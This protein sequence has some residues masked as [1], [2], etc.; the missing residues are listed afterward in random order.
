M[1]ILIYVRKKLRHDAATCKTGSAGR[2]AK[3]R[4]RIAKEGGEAMSSIAASNAWGEI[5]YHAP[6]VI[7]LGSHLRERGESNDK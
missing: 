6:S 5:V 7:L 3:V 1:L 2:D 4:Q